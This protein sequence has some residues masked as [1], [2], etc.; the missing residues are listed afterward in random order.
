V[1]TKPS[2]ST[3][4]PTT[5]KRGKGP[6]R[7]GRRSIGLTFK[8]VKLKLGLLTKLAIGLLCLHGIYTF[9]SETSAKVQS[10]V[11]SVNWDKAAD[12]YLI[13]ISIG[14]LGLSIAATKR[15]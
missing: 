10:A 14:L 1:K 3:R 8:P 12:K 4:K 13:P 5:R 15:R 7:T 6:I 9:G 11:Q 2:V